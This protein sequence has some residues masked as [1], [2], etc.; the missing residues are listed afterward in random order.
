MKK[1][2]SL[3]T[4]RCSNWVS[5]GK[6]LYK[7][8]RV[9]EAV[10]AMKKGYEIGEGSIMGD[11]IRGFIFMWSNL[12]ENTLFEEEMA[13]PLDVILE[14]YIVDGSIAVWRDDEDDDEGGNALGPKVGLELL[15]NK[16]AIMEKGIGEEEEASSGGGGKKRQK[17]LIKSARMR[18]IT[19]NRRKSNL[20][21]MGTMPNSIKEG[22]E[23]AMGKMEM[24][25]ER[26]RSSMMLK[27]D[28]K[29]RDSLAMK[30]VF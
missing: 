12:G 14:D 2:L 16:A 27:A 1:C 8:N 20:T 9:V 3:E 11:Q 24:E 21:G 23:G 5:Y 13:A 15:L 30:N 26:R 10:A 6:S 4:G 19:Y 7:L 25:M 28:Q 18:S 29:W 22:V 17:S